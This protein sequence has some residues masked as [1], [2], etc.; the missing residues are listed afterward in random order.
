MFREVFE[1]T[2]LNIEPVHIIGVYGGEEQRYTYSN[3][4]QVEYITIVFE[5]KIKDGLLNPDNEEM[6]ELKF[7]SKD[8]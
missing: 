4:Q 3:G 1:E 2:G 6:K 7:F 8:Q 5:C